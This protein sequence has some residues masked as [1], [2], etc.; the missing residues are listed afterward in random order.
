MV[1]ENKSLQEYENDL[2]GFK[3]DWKY[4]IKILENY[5]LTTIIFFKCDVK[6]HIRK[7]I[8]EY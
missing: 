7:D 5:L 6:D 4:V 1:Y 3:V 8:F 2:N